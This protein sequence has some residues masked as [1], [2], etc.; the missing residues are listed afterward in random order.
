M[1]IVCFKHPCMSDILNVVVFK[2]KSDM[3]AN[4][5]YFILLIQANFLENWIP[6]A[7]ENA[8][9]YLNFTM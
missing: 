6:K 4:M 2:C 3:Y 5:M 1:W 9:T 7:S 8:N